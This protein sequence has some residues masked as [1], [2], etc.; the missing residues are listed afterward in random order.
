[1]ICKEDLRF[2][3]KE[4]VK[5]TLEE[6]FDAAWSY[7]LD[8][9]A[10][11]STLGAERK[12]KRIF[13]GGGIMMFQI[14]K[15]LNKLRRTDRKRATQKLKLLEQELNRFSDQINRGEA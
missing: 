4:P 13:Y 3:I 5:L 15:D 1:M 9:H 7:F 11:A 10:N 12:A 14:M 8:T 6:S 2:V